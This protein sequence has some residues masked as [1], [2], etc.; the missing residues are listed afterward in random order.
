MFNNYKVTFKKFSLF[1]SIEGVLMNKIIMIIPY[2][3][4]LPDYFPFFLKSAEYNTDID[5]LLITDN[6]IKTSYK[7]IKIYKTTFKR[8]KERIQKNF[9]F[10]IE[11]SQPYKLVDYKPTY[12]LVFHDIIYSYDFWGYCDI[13]QIFGKISNFL[14][15]NIENFDKLFRLG[16]F[17]LYKNTL[18]NNKRFMSPIGM[19]YKD[20]FTSRTIFVFDE[21]EGIEKKYELLGIPRYN[22]HDFADISF[23]YHQLRRVYKGVST[24]KLNQ[25][26][27]TYYWSMGTLYQIFVKNGNIEKKELL[28]IHFQKRN[29]EGDISIIEND[30]PFFI[31]YDGF[32]PGNKK[33]I[34][35]VE[36]IKRVNKKNIVLD[37]RQYLKY[38]WYIWKRRFYKYVLKG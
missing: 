1:K 17:T 33:K 25:Y 6:N 10:K 22:K 34:K 36:Y 31:T 24:S 16:H 18:Q 29:L 4:K 30:A 9:D 11:L 21:I 32:I 35:N 23:R 27:N 20:V 2:F 7:N 13:D 5:F 8:L 14:P 37:G 15:N 19:N 12:G 3:G 38:K 26:P 28:Y